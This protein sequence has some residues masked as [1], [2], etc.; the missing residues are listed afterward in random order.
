[1]LN[2]CDTVKALSSVEKD[3]RDSVG[4]VEKLSIAGDPLSMLWDELNFGHRACRVVMIKSY[5][6]I[7]VLQY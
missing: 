5:W 6:S 2:S 3:S 1:M 4:Q 7:F